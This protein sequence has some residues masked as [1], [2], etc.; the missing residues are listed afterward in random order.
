MYL[1]RIAEKEAEA[2]DCDFATKELELKEAEMVDKFSSTKAAECQFMA[3]VVEAEHA[4][5]VR[6][7]PT[8]KPHLA[9]RY[10]S[11]QNRIHYK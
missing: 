5:P 9:R 10:L 4:S 3:K 1:Q 8:M 7:S 6:K 2:E 11:P